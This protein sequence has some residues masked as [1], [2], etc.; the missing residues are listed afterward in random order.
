MKSIPAGVGFY[1][2]RSLRP[3][4]L[5]FAIGAVMLAAGTALA[6]SQFAVTTLAGQYN[7]PGSADGTLA[8]RFNNPYG[9]AIDGA[10]NIYVADSTTHIIRKITP[11]GVVSTVAGLAGAA[12]EANGTTTAR[13]D[14]PRGVAVNAAGTILYVADTNNHTIRAID[15]TVSPA[16]VTTLAG[17][18]DSA[19]STDATGAAARFNFPVAV[20][21]DGTNLFV[22]DSTNHSIRRIIVSTAVVSTLAGPDGSTGNVPGTAGFVDATGAA[23]RF[24]VP[25]A[26]AVDNTRVFV[27]DRNNHRVR[28][29]TISSGLV[30]TLAGTGSAG[31]TDAPSGPATSASFSGLSG[32][33]ANSNG[34]SAATTVFTTESTNV[35]RRI[36]LSGGAVTTVAGQPVANAYVDG[37]GSNARFSNPNGIGLD[38]S[39]NFYVAD[40]SA[41]LI[42]KGT[43]ATAPAITSA[44]N[45]AFAVGTAGTFT[46]TSTG[47]PPATF[48]IN[49][50]T[51]PTGVTFTSNAGTNTATLAG[52]PAAGTAGVYT[53]TITANNGVTPAA[54]QTFTLNVNQVPVFTSTNATTFPINTAAS[55]QVTASGVPAPTFSIISG[56]LPGFVASMNPGG[57]ITSAQPSSVSG[58]YTF[59]I[60]ASNAAGVSDQSFTLTIASTTPPTVTPP[61]SV[62]L[63]A[64]TTSTSFTVTASGTP[65]DFTYQWQR[66][67]V[68]TGVFVNLPSP[69][70]TVDGATYTGV[71]TP[72]LTINGITG[73]MNGDA[74]QVI[75]TSSGGST[76]SAIA[77]MG[78]APT[79]TSPANVTFANNQANSFTFTASGNPAPIFNVTGTLP[80][81]VT[82]SGNGTSAPNISGTPTDV[83]TTNY[84][85]SVQATN[86]G[87]STFQ[88]FTLTVSPPQSPIIT[89]AQSATFNVGQLGTHVFTASGSPAPSIQL[90]GSLPN[91]VTFN[92]TTNTLSGTP[93]DVLGSPFTFT[94]IA[95]NSSGQSQ[96]TFTLTIQGSPPTIVTHPVST[97]ANIGQTGVTFT[98][99]AAGTP[100]P[101]IRWQ[102]QPAGTFGFVNLTDDGTF[103]GTNS[104]ILTINNVTAAM[105]LD[106]FR[107]VA[108]NGSG[109]EA[110]SNPATLTVN[111]GIVISTLAGQAGLVGLA[112]G[113]ASSARFNTPSGIANDFAGNLYIADTANHVIRKLT[114]GGTVS[115]FAGL[116]GFN[117]SAD[118]NG[119]AA[120]F[121][122]PQGVAVDGA[123]NVYVADTFNHT[124]R[125]ITPNGDVTT[126]GGLPGAPGAADGI[127]TNAR[128]NTPT[129]VA[130]N[131]IGTVYVADS[132]NHAIRRLTRNGAEVTVSTFAGILNV[133][134]H[135]DAN[136][137]S[138]RFNNPNGVALDNGGNLFVGDSLNYVVRRISSFGDVVTVAGF[139]GNPGSGDG[140]GSGA[141]FNRPTGVAV[142]SSGNVYVADTNNHTI[143]KITSGGEVTTLAG[144]AGS[145]GSTDGSGLSARFNQPVGVAVDFSGNVFIADTRNHTLRRSGAPFAPQFTQH[146]ANRVAG[147]GQLV[148]FTAT[149]TG[150]PTPGYQWQ[151]Q[152]VTTPGIFVNLSN[153]GTYTGVNTATLTIINVNQ[154]MTGDQFRVIANNGVPSPAIS[155][156]ATL[157]VGTPPMFTSPGAVSFQ[158]GQSNSFRVIVTSDPAA[159]FSATGLPSW[160]NLNAA[161]G[162]ITGTPPDTTGSPFT[163]VITANNGATATQTLTLTVTPAL[164]APTI[165]TQPAP[166]ALNQGQT[167]T[168]SV[169]VSGTPP[170]T[171]TW[172]RNGAIINGAT[173][174]TLTLANVQPSSAGL[175]NVTITN[176]AG[177]TVS[178]G[179][180]VSINTIPTITVQPAPQATVV[181]GTV[182]F[183]VLATGSS[184]FGYQ[185]RRNGVPIAGAN[186]STLTLTNVSANDAGNYDV[187][188]SNG[189]GTSGSSLAQLTIVTGQTAPVITRQPAG[190]TVIAGTSTTLSAAASGVPAP[191]VQWF[192]NG[193]AVTGATSPNLT[194]SSVATGD[195]GG[196]NAVFT[197]AAGTVTSAVAALN[198]ITRSYAGIY[199]GNFGTLGDFALYIRD[200]NTGVF[201]G[202]LPGSLAPVMSLNVTVND[203]G[204]FS[205]AQGAIA[206]TSSNL[207]EPARAAALGAVTVAGTIGTDGSLTGTLSGAATGSLSG[208][209]APDSGGSGGIAGYY[210]A[211]GTTNAAVAYTIVGPHNL[212]FV[213]AQS[214]NT[215]EGGRG[216]V[217]NAGQVIV[218]TSR[219]TIVENIAD[220]RITGSSTGAVIANFAGATDS[221]LA[222]QRL[223]NISSRAR[224][225]AAEAVAIAG[226]VIAGEESKPVLIRAVGPALTGLGVAGALAAPRLELF[227]AGSP[228]PLLVNT[229][230]GANRGDIDAAGSGAGA[231]PLTATDAAILTTL[232]PGNYTAVLSSNVATAT[233]VALVEVYDLSAATPGQKLLNISTRAAAGTNENTL[234][235]GFVVP[236]GP[237][238]R[239]L[240]RGIGP[241]L[242]GFGISGTLPAPTLTVL[243]GSSPVATNTNW[244]AGGD[245]AAITTASAQVGA[246]TLLPAVAD[247]AVVV[248][249]EPGNYTAQVT[250]AAGATGIALIEVYELP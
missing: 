24:N 14:S 33:A 195:A 71:N 243:R 228:T 190:R 5:F 119:S 170:F 149:A 87:G 82:L 104:S 214:G 84:P 206:S 173:G 50:T 118:G 38:G 166:I 184:T 117:G 204:Q 138:A 139:P 107:I 143:R 186:T 96:Q 109:V 25:F 236:P 182:S 230:I 193:V 35:I 73:A 111:L 187:Q 101:T 89:S 172:R 179:A 11:A 67:P 39:G 210:Q 163:I 165:T 247:S 29:I 169:V 164:L 47:S 156:T 51:L 63:P 125:V 208:S 1:P 130:V 8:A 49:P 32:I 57:L 44:N 97:T 15:L 238:K 199:F 194:I 92:P 132:A 218:T 20:A 22:A 232:A 233:G 180:A 114:P 26:L 153:D 54:T 60:R 235:A 134:G 151:R 98:A 181:G 144:L 162:E 244:A 21:F 229:G 81:G 65:N 237:A 126:M 202:Y 90:F 248:T 115:T 147:I 80:N 135:V 31:S 137:T 17:T 241:G 234:I 52:T 201:L 197:N 189:L 77:T 123:G 226:F 112:D 203:A 152:P 36:V 55:F 12:G 174:S 46:V 158:A 185:W 171:Y 62:S 231:F 157:T 27:A 246:F 99:T 48:T 200:D 145:S 69:S 175:Y 222:Q 94:V 131:V 178:N 19:G 225:G 91:G 129:A 102:R 249:L 168:L 207:D 16:N 53:F 76:T 9:A 221:F 100:T 10:G 177:T 127:G 41:H 240:V 83:F 43:L 108:N 121:N 224:V 212:S 245:A 209:R 75:V 142:D 45:T 23:A 198:V 79:I 56:N 191:T 58:P 86:T 215:Y 150:A 205:F 40:T 66:R 128:F 103:V 42:R 192:K 64:G 34:S 6:Q 223:V 120:R 74:F 227:R 183:S 113:P 105:S 211:G 154:S 167:A 217:T 141:R 148:N 59:T 133:A 216:T 3:A 176:A 7:S 93:T 160:A 161:T 85:L 159:V 116:A 220:G 28:V 37:I 4:R 188:V 136:G 30:Q 239:V 213:V 70:G 155:N 88:S 18:A 219:A 124:I 72:T 2:Q 78:V 242:A 110:T 106:Q 146:P 68:G 95:Q 122:S 196:Y 13:F 250:N 61:V 140:I